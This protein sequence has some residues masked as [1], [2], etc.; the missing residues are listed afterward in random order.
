MKK[1]WQEK[2]DEHYK[3]HYA[4]LEKLLTEIVGQEICYLVDFEATEYQ[5]G[6]LLK[7]NSGHFRI[8][9]SHPKIPAP[10]D[11]SIP[12]KEITDIVT[13]EGKPAINFHSGRM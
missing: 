5:E 11:L 7:T 2:V 1:T 10:Y 6:V 9:I 3:N 12:V 8:L 4:G 13:R